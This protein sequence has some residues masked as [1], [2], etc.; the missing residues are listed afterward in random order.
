M[1]VHLPFVGSGESNIIVD[2]GNGT[3]TGTLIGVGTVA[4]TLL[5]GEFAG[6]FVSLFRTRVKEVVVDFPFVPLPDKAE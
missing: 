3:N 2:M 1:I 4:G 5:I 6:V